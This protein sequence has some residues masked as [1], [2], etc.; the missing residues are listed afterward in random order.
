M[1]RK[2]KTL[3]FVAVVLP[4]FGCQPQSSASSKSTKGSQ[5]L[6]G[7]WVGKHK[8]DPNR[9]KEGKESNFLADRLGGYTLKLDEDGN[10]LADWRGLSKEG[11]WKVSGS[12]VE[13][14][15]TRVFGKTRAEA[16]EENSS[17][18]KT[19][20]DIALFDADTRLE[21]RADKSQIT[22]PAQQKDSEAVIFSRQ[23]G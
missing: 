11:I 15:I 4:I 6:A 21:I 17:A 10:F 7:V 8:E 14:T 16:E 23:K 5:N 1:N 2:Y 18:G 3:L 13:L 9:P 22:L 12:T 19:I 20:N